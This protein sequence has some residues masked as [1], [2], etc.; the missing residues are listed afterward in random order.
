MAD[1]LTGSCLHMPFWSF[2][3]KYHENKSM[4]NHVKIKLVLYI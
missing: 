4:Y 1:D 2:D 3:A